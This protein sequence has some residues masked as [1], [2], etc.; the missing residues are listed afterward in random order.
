MLLLGLYS[1]YM[2]FLYSDQ[3][4]SLDLSSKP[5]IYKNIIQKSYVSGDVHNS[6]PFLCFHIPKLGCDPTTDIDSPLPNF[7]SHLN[8]TL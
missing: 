3:N 4:I 1:I 7:A 6:T 2:I 5:D 8:S